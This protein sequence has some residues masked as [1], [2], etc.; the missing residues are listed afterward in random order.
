MR[1]N[2]FRFWDSKNKV[3]Y[4]AE[5]PEFVVTSDGEVGRLIFDE[6]DTKDYIEFEGTYYSKHIIPLQYTGLCDKN[7]TEIYEGDILLQRWDSFDRLRI[8]GFKNGSFVATNHPMERQRFN[9]FS[10][11]ETEEHSSTL[12]HWEVIGNIYE[13]PELLEGAE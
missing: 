10:L 6:T 4:P 1:E 9:T 5:T 12:E 13:N 11:Y 8:V 2:K 7:G 3:M